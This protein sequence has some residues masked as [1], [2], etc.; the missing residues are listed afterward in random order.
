MFKWTHKQIKH[1]DNYVN[2]QL[3]EWF[4]AAVLSREE[5]S[6]NVRQKPKVEKK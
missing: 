1:V 5:K 3:N 6:L 4:T 2:T